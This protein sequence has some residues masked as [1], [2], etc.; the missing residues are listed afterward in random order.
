MRESRGLA[1]RT[2]IVAVLD[3]LLPPAPSIGD[4][5]RARTAEVENALAGVPDDPAA[6]PGKAAA[7]VSKLGRIGFDLPD[8]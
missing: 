3:G 2:R 6:H 7:A 8:V 1:N 4:R 5:L